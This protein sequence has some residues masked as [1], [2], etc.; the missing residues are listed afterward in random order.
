MEEGLTPETT[1][2][3]L[4]RFFDEG[5]VK[6]RAFRGSD[7]SSEEALVIVKFSAMHVGNRVA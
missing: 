6:L 2:E 3:R 5:T 4:K 1:M 7:D